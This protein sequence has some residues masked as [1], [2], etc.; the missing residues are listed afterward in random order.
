MLMYP[1]VPKDEPT[2][3]VDEVPVSQTSDVDAAPP[4]E[5]TSPVQTT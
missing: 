2:I 3:G 1:Y 5:P 4:T